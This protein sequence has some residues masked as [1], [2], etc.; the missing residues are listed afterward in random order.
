MSEPNQDLF[1]R[2][3]VREARWEEHYAYVEFLRFLSGG[4]GSVCWEVVQD[5]HDFFFRDFPPLLPRKTHR[6]STF[7]GE[8]TQPISYGAVKNQR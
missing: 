7:F 4:F 3:E 2:V 6:F 1:Y 8:V 5:H